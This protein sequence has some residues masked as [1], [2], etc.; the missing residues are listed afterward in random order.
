MSHQHYLLWQ[1]ECSEIP[2][3]EITK[4]VEDAFIG[5]DVRYDDI[6]ILLKALVRNESIRSIRFEGDFL[7][8]LQEQ[9]RSELIRAVGS[10]LPSLQ[11]ICLGD[12]PIFVADLC[13]LVTKSKRLRYL[14]LHDL[15]LQG[16]PED[17][18][19]LEV[20]LLHHPFKEFDMNECTSTFPGIDLMK[21]K[22]AESKELRL[23]QVVFQQCPNGHLC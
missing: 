9:R 12:T 1:I 11:K 17:F 13:H 15:I 20:A 8:C 16:Q 14:Y 23:K 22:N 2:I 19:A 10:Y 5:S 4:E 21:I 7:D 18:R 3:L 6:T